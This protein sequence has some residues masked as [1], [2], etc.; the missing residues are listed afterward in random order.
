[1]ILLLLDDQAVADQGAVDAR[2]ARRRR[3]ATLLKLVRD[4]ARTP[5]RVRTAQLADQRPGLGRHPR[6]R[7]VRPP[8]AV[9]QPGQAVSLVPGQ[10]RVHRLSGHT[11]LAGGLGHRNAVENTQHHAVAV[12]YLP[13]WV[14]A[15][16][17][18]LIDRHRLKIKAQVSKQVLNPSRVS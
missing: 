16:P 4:A 5:P 10:P 6:W 14:I 12:S 3:D 2:A 11:G 17:S 8:R 9:R 15:D 18:S 13:A 1:V 7:G